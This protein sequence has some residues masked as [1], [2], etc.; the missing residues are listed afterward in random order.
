MSA[1]IAPSVILHVSCFTSHGVTCI[2]PAWTRIDVLL[3]HVLPQALSQ[4]SS[5]ASYSAGTRKWWQFQLDAD[6]KGVL[7]RILRSET[8][9]VRYVGAV[10]LERRSTRVEKDLIVDVEDQV[11]VLEREIV[12]NSQSNLHRSTPGILRQG[13]T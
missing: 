1:A 6:Q 12:P 5:L 10:R 9:K 4:S 11:H 13:L 8:V 2:T 3:V 7:V